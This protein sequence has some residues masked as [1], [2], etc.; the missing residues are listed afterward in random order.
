MERNTVYPEPAFGYTGDD[1][2]DDEEIFIT[3]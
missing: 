2:D 1:D 3:P